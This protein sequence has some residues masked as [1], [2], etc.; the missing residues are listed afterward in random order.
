MPALL[1][2]HSPCFH[3][4]KTLAEKLRHHSIYIGLRRGGGDYYNSLEETRPPGRHRCRWGDNK[5]DGE[6]CVWNGVIRIRNWASD[7]LLW[8][9]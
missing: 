9:W 1:S 5:W 4:H 2:H 3:A 8:M 7:R 6:G